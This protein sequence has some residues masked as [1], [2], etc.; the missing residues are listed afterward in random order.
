MISNKETC[1]CTFLAANRHHNTGLEPRKNLSLVQ[2]SFVQV[3]AKAPDEVRI[4]AG[5]H[6]VH[7]STYVSTGIYYIS[8]L[9]ETWP[10]DKNPGPG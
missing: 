8:F 7:V 5:Y 10:V 2:N 1:I 9:P 3:D 6:M 4:C